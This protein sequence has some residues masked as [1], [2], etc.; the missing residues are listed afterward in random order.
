MFFKFAGRSALAALL[1]S[2]VVTQFAPPIYAQ[3]ASPESKALNH[4]KFVSGSI[5][6]C[7]AACSA[8]SGPFEGQDAVAEDCDGTCAC[9]GEQLGARVSGDDLWKSYK[10]EIAGAS[11]TE[12]MAPY[13]PSI[14]MGY[15]ACGFEIQ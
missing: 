7:M 1:V 10:A 3:E 5:A 2:M 12:A 6:A 11:R 9:V 8:K 15:R 4:S 14:I 13:T